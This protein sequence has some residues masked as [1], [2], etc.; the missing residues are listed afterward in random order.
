MSDEDK[1]ML[2]PQNIRTIKLKLTK[3]SFRQDDGGKST[4]LIYE[5]SDNHNNKTELLKS[6]KKAQQHI[7]E[8]EEFDDVSEFGLGSDLEDSEA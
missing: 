7:A 4:Q 2:D 1:K 5:L 8:M 3:F 6:V